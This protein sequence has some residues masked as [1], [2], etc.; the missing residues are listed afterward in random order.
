MIVIRE[1]D[2]HSDGRHAAEAEG[3]SSSVAPTWLFKGSRNPNGKTAQAE[4]LQ[5]FI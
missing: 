1:L 5:H 3:G 2:P 4:A